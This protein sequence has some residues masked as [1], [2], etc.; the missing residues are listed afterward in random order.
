MPILS[1]KSLYL[2]VI[3]Y[4]MK[5]YLKEKISAIPLAERPREKL[6]YQGVSALADAE[7]IALLIGSG[8]RKSRVEKIS[9]TV[10]DLLDRYNGS[11]TVNQLI[12]VPGIGKAKASV[13]LAALEFSR[14]R[15]CPDRRRIGS[16]KDILPL[17]VHYANRKQE[18]FL[19]LSLNGAHEVIAIRV[20]SIG[21]VNRS[22]VHPREVF[23]DPLQDRAAAIVIAHNHPSGNLE[24]S[25]EDVQVTQRLKTVADILGI[26]LLDHIVFSEEGYHSF[27]EHGRL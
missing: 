25:E 13:I 11:L 18:Y 12:E 21:L 3:T 4:R 9:S 15:L 1:S 26:L 24:P 23:A 5:L 8:N 16:P 14:R 17:V 20:V 10:L 7:L 2:I 6:C 22:L 19:C 27:L